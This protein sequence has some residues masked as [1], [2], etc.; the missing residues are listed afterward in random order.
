MMTHF[1]NKDLEKPIFG[2]NIGLEPATLFSLFFRFFK[3]V[4]NR[5]R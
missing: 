3:A 5:Q 1:G 2:K 4:Q